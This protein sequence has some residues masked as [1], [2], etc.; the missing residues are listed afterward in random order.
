[1]RCGPASGTV[2]RVI[3]GDTIELA[4]GEIVRYLHVDT[5]ELGDT[6]EC[7]A[8]EAAAYNRQLVEGQTVYLEYDQEC[9]G[10]Y[11]R[12]LAIVCIDGRMVNSVLLQRG[13]A[14]LYEPGNSPNV[15][16]FESMQSAAAAAQA[17]NAG[18]W[19][20]CQ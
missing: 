16:Y 6:P 3:D 5:P 12:L 20:R 15:K 10:Y 17:N 19:G 9:T 4:S 13:Y 7:Y 11:G 1:M 2:S 18:L 14:R 8:E